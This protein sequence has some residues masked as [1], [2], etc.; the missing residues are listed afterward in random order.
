MQTAATGGATKRREPDAEEQLLA[1]S[2][3]VWDGSVASITALVRGIDAMGGASL[4]GAPDLLGGV[5]GAPNRAAD[6]SGSSSSSRALGQDHAVSPLPTPGP[7]TGGQRASSTGAAVTPA[8][9]AASVSLAAAA[10]FKTTAVLLALR[11]RAAIDVARV[12]ECAQR[13]TEHACRRQVLAMA[14]SVPQALAEA[15]LAAGVP[16]PS[17]GSK[18]KHASG[19]AAVGLAPDGAPA[20]AGSAIGRSVQAF[21]ADLEQQRTTLRELLLEHA[22]AAQLKFQAA[23]QPDGMGQP[24]AGAT[25]DTAVLA[26]WHAHAAMRALHWLQL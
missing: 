1:A 12:P 18:Q 25:S 14:A 2:P 22:A 20:A 9:A 5:G 4:T 10:G 6:S 17:H 3:E 26:A 15:R 16:A 7:G 21:E 24:I 11:L 19:A 13:V 23:V 8:A